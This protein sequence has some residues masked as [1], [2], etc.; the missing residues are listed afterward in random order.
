MPKELLNMYMKRV[1]DRCR[2][3]APH[4]LAESIELPHDPDYW[5]R[6]DSP[7]CG[8]FVGSLAYAFAL[9]L[10]SELSSTSGIAIEINGEDPEMYVAQMLGLDSG[11]V[12]LAG[13][14]CKT[15]PRDALAVDYTLDLLQ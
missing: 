6:C 7:I 9:E 14:W 15:R 4:I 12:E 8:C 2:E 3:V 11:V 5:L 13:M 10:G 1:I